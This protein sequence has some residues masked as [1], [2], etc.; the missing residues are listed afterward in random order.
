MQLG[1]N[2]RTRLILLGMG[3][4]IVLCSL[5]ALVYAFWPEESL[6]TQ[7]TLAPTLLVPP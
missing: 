5:V 4:L 1:M 2:K 6:R 7:A 3:V